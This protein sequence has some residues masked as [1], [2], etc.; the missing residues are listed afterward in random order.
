MNTDPIDNAIEAY[1][2]AMT[3]MEPLRLKI[4]EERQLTVSQLRLTHL[5]RD[6]GNVDRDECYRVMNM[7]VGM[8]LVSS[9]TDVDPLLRALA[10]AG[11]TGAAVIG[12]LE[13][14]PRECVV[15]FGG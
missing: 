3:V 6:R 9:P 12:R 13:S 7:G 14:G 15:R 10:A 8:V 11:E 1:G 2:R 5:I 4:W